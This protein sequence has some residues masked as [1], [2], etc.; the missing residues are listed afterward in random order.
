MGNAVSNNCNLSF[1]D[2][3]DIRNKDILIHTMKS[4]DLVIS[5]TISMLKEEHVINKLMSEKMFD[6]LIVIYGKHLNDN[7]VDKKMEQLHSLGFTNI[8]VYRG[9]IFEWLLLQD[10]Y[11]VENFPTNRE[12]LDILAWRP[13]KLFTNKITL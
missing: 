9:G 1:E 4:D 10:I 8:G 13:P 3:Q 5:G 7:L 12:E 2:V 6:K 11:G